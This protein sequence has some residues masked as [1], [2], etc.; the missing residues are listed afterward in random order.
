MKNVAQIIINFW[1]IFEIVFDCDI[2]IKYIYDTYICVTKSD[3]FSLAPNYELSK[4]HDLHLLQ[5]NDVNVKNI[6]RP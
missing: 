4:C 3:R 5:I 2:L 6:F 1:K